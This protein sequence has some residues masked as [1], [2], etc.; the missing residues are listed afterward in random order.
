MLVE[1]AGMLTT[2]Q[3]NG[4]IGCRQFG[5]STNG[6]MDNLAPYLIN[7][8]LENPVTTAVIE[9]TLMGPVLYF[10]VDS[11]I[12]IGGGMSEPQL[13]GVP[14][15]CWTP[16]NIAA[17]QRLAL[18]NV[19]QGC[20]GY[21]AV[22][23]GLN[24]PPVLSSRSTYLRAGIGGFKGRALEEGDEIPIIACH[25]KA[26][27]YQPTWELTHYLDSVAPIR[28]VQSTQ[29]DWFTPQSQHDFSS[30]SYTISSESDR[31][32]Y[33]LTGTALQ[34]KYPQELLSEGVCPGSIQVPNDGQP[35][36]LMSDCQPTGGYPKI[37]QVASVDLAALAQRQPGQ[38]VHFQN[39]TVSQA[40]QALRRRQLDLQ[41]LGIAVSY[42]WS[43]LNH[44]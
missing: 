40:H 38:T 32:G 21:L 13:D 17:G 3:D 5:F 19:Y 42:K 2:I 20:R 41:R 18:G 24:I 1:N 6:C 35:I 39:I 43:E 44:V 10:S 37:G 22:K 26:P 27:E 16:L 36:V 30:R 23:G 25:R 14:V 11:I 4:R 33:R 12:C 9:Y 29:Y 8:M 34:K 7:I 31:M 15:P 28:Y